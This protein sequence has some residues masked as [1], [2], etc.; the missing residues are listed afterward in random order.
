M[1]PQIAVHCHHGNST[2]IRAKHG[3]L[4]LWH[5]QVTRTSHYKSSGLS[6]IQECSFARQNS[7]EMSRVRTGEIYGIAPSIVI[8]VREHGPSAVGS[9][10]CQPSLGWNTHPD[11]PPTQRASKHATSISPLRDPFS[12]TPPG[13]PVWP[14][15]TER[16]RRLL[17]QP[18]PQARRRVC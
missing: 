4:P 18:H 15:H 6:D 1:G 16:V 8:P 14:P 13:T 3:P 12:P 5:T 9:P 10:A 11:S 2:G 17:R 7:K